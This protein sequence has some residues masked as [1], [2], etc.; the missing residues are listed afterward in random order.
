M[1]NHEALFDLGTRPE[2]VHLALAAIPHLSPADIAAWQEVIDAQAWQGSDDVMR[3]ITAFRKPPPAEV[4]D[5]D[6]ATTRRQIKYRLL[7]ALDPVLPAG[8]AAELAELKAE[9]GALEHPEFGSYMTT[10]FVGPTSPVDHD[11]LGAMSSDTLR[12]LLAT[13]QPADDYHFGPSVEG[14]ARELALVAENQPDLLAALAR[15]LLSLGRSYVRA[16]V[17]GWAKA[18]QK[19]F[20]PTPGVWN[21]LIALV[22]LPDSGENTS[23]DFSA[24]D[25]AW[26]WAQRS[27]ADFATSYLATRG[28]ELTAD[29]AERLWE[30]LG[31]LTSHADPTPQHEKQFGG[32]NMDPMT[33]SLNTTRPTAIRAAIK[34][35][36][37]VAKRSS[38]EFSPA[39]TQIFSML[40]GHVDAA[41]DPSLAVAAV[42][43]EA[44]GYIWDIDHA[45][46]DD[47]SGKLFAV[48]STEDAARAHADVVVSVALRIYRTGTPFLQLMRPVILSML[49][50]PYAAVGH[51]D[52]WRGNRPALQA[53][54]SHI[55]TAYV[56]GLIDDEDPLVTAL[57]SPEVSPTVISDALGTLGW[58]LMQ[59]RTAE[60][61]PPE[62]LERAKRLIDRRV[63][64]IQAGQASASELGGFYWWIRAEAF[65][66]AWSLPILQLAARAPDFNPHGMLGESLAHA[67]EAEP[68]LTINVFDDLMSVDRQ[69]WNQHDLLRHA[70]RIL[71]AALTS[72]D[73]AAQGK[74]RAISDRLGREGHMTVLADIDR[75][76][77]SE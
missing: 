16:A 72:T 18:L 60:P 53:A 43:G 38:E 68:T 62:A 56:M 52:G 30:I 22:Q 47:H 13:W 4:S 67:A 77:A 41:D 73:P 9:F 50:T 58:S 51:T 23:A 26:R 24:D 63:A 15:D 34:L 2:Y 27:A 1:L 17:A 29:E 42:I 20:Q 45:W 44:L 31:P 74:A 59:A 3:E 10:G 37:A 46:I 12:D 33:L 55:V 40:S 25:A 5:D 69:D 36:R 49:S 48:L 65:P 6:V 76:I 35:L 64:E 11:A 14:L 39:K 8:P 75:L 71:A 66:A 54:A 57:A 7:L 32:S 61:T 28:D 21:M 70:P 19:G